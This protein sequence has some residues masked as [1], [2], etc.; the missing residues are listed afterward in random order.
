MVNLCWIFFLVEWAK[1]ARAGKAGKVSQPPPSSNS[2]LRIQLSGQYYSTIVKFE[3]GALDLALQPRPN[4]NHSSEKLFSW[5]L[6]Y[7]INVQSGLRKLILLSCVFWPA[8]RCFVLLVKII[9]FV[10]FCS[11]A[12]CD[13]LLGK[14]R[15]HTVRFPHMG[16]NPYL[17]D[18]LLTQG[19]LYV[20]YQSER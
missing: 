6:A 4:N 17:W 14:W 7:G 15:A 2:V 1:S 11:Q 13:N 10:V 20:S 8:N 16:I 12:Y 5:R 18:A 19:I 3:F 9:L